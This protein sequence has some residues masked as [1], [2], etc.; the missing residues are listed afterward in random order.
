MKGRR[1]MAGLSFISPKY[2]Q[3]AECDSLSGKTESATVH[4]RRP[5]LLLIA[6]IVGAM[7]FLMGAAVYTRW[8]NSMQ[9]R[10]KPSEKAR[11]QAEKSGLSVIYDPAET[12]DGSVL[13]ATDQGI[14]VT[15]VQSIADKRRVQ[16]VLRV[17]GFTPPEGYGV[18]PNVWMEIP[19]TLGGDEHFWGSASERFD[20]GIVQAE[21]KSWV[22]EDGTP[23]EVNEKGWEK[24]RFIKADGS[25]ELVVSYYFH[26]TSG[27]NL[28][29]E[30]QL[31]FTGFGTDTTIGKAEST[32]E[33]LVDGHWDLRFPL[34]GSDDIIKI[35]PNLR[36]SDNVTLLDIQIGQLTSRA[37]YKTD[38]YWDG[39]KR[40]ESL[41]P[42]LAGIQMKD[43]TFIQLVEASQGYEDR[44]NLIYFVEYM[45]FQATVDMEKVE[46]LAYYDGWEYDENG[47]PT[48]PIYKYV[49]IE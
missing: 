2:I 24:G 35:S 46:A 43:G 9:Q 47:E 8:S 34:K 5:R 29:K 32:Y 10:Y 15:V 41:M 17:E 23:I 3:E 18:S 40:I 27:A 49:P 4:R 11:Q 13:S 30:L 42:G 22:Y 37:R 19:A 26:D 12:E 39:W 33:K 44:D 14:T 6:A 28:G 7:L 48:I 31:H 36:L 38:T 16:I 1:V 21:D 20:D 25:M 45:T